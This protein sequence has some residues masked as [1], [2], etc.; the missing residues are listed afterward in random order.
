MML[1]SG[2]TGESGPR[3]LPAAI[4]STTKF[5]MSAA[6]KESCRKAVTAAEQQTHILAL[7]IG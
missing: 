7:C 3:R 5:H 1:Q 2:A 4:K 6:T